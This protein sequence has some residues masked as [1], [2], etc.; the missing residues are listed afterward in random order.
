[1]SYLL[2][3]PFSILPALAYVGL[4][5]GDS[6]L[7][8]TV[9]AGASGW[10][11]ALIVWEAK[12]Y[13]SRSIFG[14]FTV[15]AP[16]YPVFV[17]LLVTILL[18]NASFWGHLVGMAAGYLYTYGFIRFLVPGAYHFERVENLAIARPLTRA[19]R[20]VKAETDGLVWLPV[21]TGD[22]GSNIIAS[23]PFAS[24]PAPRTE[25]QSEHRFPGAGVRLGD[26]PASNAG[27][28]TAP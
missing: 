9:V 14:L 15:P 12:R 21:H 10:A 3:V 17:L 27:P 28:S 7:H 19:R 6:G 23:N 1:T 20:F 22:T 26:S 5:L 16:L 25:L 18:P 24:S 13:G 4:S 8:E 11:F 2:L